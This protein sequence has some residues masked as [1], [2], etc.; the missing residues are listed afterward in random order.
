MP[1]IPPKFRVGNLHGNLKVGKDSPELETTVVKPE[2]F[3]GTQRSI[4]PS[5]S[6]NERSGAEGN[7]L[8]NV[9]EDASF[10]DSEEWIET[11]IKLV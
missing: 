5:D 7:L 1:L 10:D 4:D 2:G 9:K 8:D 11:T 3:Q 6:L